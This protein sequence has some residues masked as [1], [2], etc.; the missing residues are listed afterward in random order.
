MP[1][2]CLLPCAA[3]APGLAFGSHQS[4]LNKR[5]QPTLTWFYPFSHRIAALA[6]G[7]AILCGRPSCCGTGAA[8]P[9]NPPA[10]ARGSAPL[11]RPAAAALLT[12]ATVGSLLGGW[13]CCPPRCSGTGKAVGCC[14]RQALTC[15]F[16]TS[17]PSTAKD[18]VPCLAMF[19]KGMRHPYD[20][21]PASALAPAPRAAPASCAVPA[22]VPNTKVAMLS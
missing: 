11:V 13:G 12:D 10:Q 9:G 5:F 21:H 17:P 8:A 16:G 15:A 3:V 1:T 18:C 7:R 19:Y 14:W 22:A 4:T 20:P 2:P 6:P